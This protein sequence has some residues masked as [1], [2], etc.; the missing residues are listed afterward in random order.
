MPIPRSGFRVGLWTGQSDEIAASISVKC[1]SAIAPEKVNN[2]VVLNFPSAWADNSYQRTKELVGET[3]R[4]VVKSFKPEWAVVT[5]TD[6]LSSVRETSKTGPFV[7]WISYFESAVKGSR[8]IPPYL[9]ERL[10]DDG[11]LFL[12]TESFDYRNVA[13]GQEIQNLQDALC[14]AKLI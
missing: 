1:G 8:P 5:S 9:Q 3:L 6:H 4:T 7:G 14:A 10:N 12:T 2:S 13:V 11:L